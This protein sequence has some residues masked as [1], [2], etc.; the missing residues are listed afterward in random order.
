MMRLTTRIVEF[1]RFLRAHAFPVGIQ[2][3]RDALEA[4]RSVDI[5]E[6]SDVQFALRAVLSSSKEESDLF[7]QLFE[8]F[9]NQTA[10]CEAGCSPRTNNIAQSVIG[11]EGKFARTLPSHEPEMEM[12]MSQ[13][14]G[15][16]AIER[17]K[18]TDFSQIPVSDLPLLEEI[19]FRFWKQMTM[20]LVRRERAGERDERLDFRRTIRAAIGHGGDPIDLR[21]RGKKKRRLRLVTLLDVSGS[22]DLYSLFLVRFLYALHK[23]FKRIDSF[24]F[25]TRLTY[26]GRAL[27]KTDLIAAMN[28]VSQKVEDWSGGTRIGECMQDFNRR[29]AKKIVSRNSLVIILSDGWDTGNPDLLAEELQLIKRRARKLIWMNPLL[30]LKDYQPLTRGMAVALP[31]TDVFAAAHNLQSLLELEKHLSWN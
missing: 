13:T 5:T 17:L 9:W 24:V 14:T 15:A 10:A 19:A 11:V 6:R 4:I 23:Y 8:E 27:Q 21:F 28:A 16:S 22:M 1:C 3:T 26:L 25:S 29:Y 18:T 7:D 20:R 30:G 31:F 2:E 12:E